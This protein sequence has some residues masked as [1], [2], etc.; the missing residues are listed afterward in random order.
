MAEAET[1]RCLRCEQ[2]LP[3]TD[4]RKNHK[5][6][7]G[8]SNRCKPC[9]NAL[10]HARWAAMSADERLDKRSQYRAQNEAFRA[11]NP[12]RVKQQKAAH[13]QRTSERCKERC[14]DWRKKNPER[15]RALA[16][17]WSNRRR[18]L[19]QGG[20]TAKQQADWASTQAKVCH[21]CGKRCA[22]KYQIDHIVPLV[23]GGEHQI[24]NLAITCPQCNLRKNS[25][26]PIEWAQMIGKLL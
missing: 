6:A 23:R 21:W 2:V 17:G 1:R 13:Y 20:I 16:R 11:A 7:G 9:L 15:F 5:M 18:E 22:R 3:L 10:D 8:Y 25:R 24:A 12:L 26:D 14:Y 4:F 19:V